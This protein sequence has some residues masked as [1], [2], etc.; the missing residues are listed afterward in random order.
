MLTLTLLCGCKF[1]SHKQ[2]IILTVVDENLSPK[3]KRKRLTS[4]ELYAA[5]NDSIRIL[6]QKAIKSINYENGELNISE[7]E[8]HWDSEKYSDIFWYQ[9]DFK[10]K[11]QK[12]KIGN[13]LYYFTSCF[14]NGSEIKILG[15]FVL[16]HQFSNYVLKDS[17]FNIIREDYYNAQWTIDY[18]LAFTH[19]SLPLAVFKVG[20]GEETVYYKETI[21][22]FDITK[23][24]LIGDN[25]PTREI[26]DGADESAG[27]S[28]KSETFF[29]DS[30]FVNGYPDFVI[31][32]K[33]TVLENKKVVDYNKEKTFKFNGDINKYK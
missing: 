33:G 26:F 13:E 20:Q 3:A 29:S 17:S 4:E 30:S 9:G 25:I 2:G 12:K 8:L 1:N 10:L 22:L 11:V 5:F 19:D 15:F 7:D 14:P 6:Y 18:N 31:K 28:W 21:A 23:R 24:K 27:Y 16:E 32:T